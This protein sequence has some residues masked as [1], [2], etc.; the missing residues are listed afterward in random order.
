MMFLSTAPTHP[1][2][3]SSG[4]YNGHCCNRNGVNCW[5]RVS[6]NAQR[7]TWTLETEALFPVSTLWE[8]CGKMMPKRITDCGGLD[9]RKLK[10]GIS[11]I[12]E[13]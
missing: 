13:G 3:C 10:S 1:K 9:F 8:A 2:V 11:S 4:L 7:L 12:V 5:A 6:G